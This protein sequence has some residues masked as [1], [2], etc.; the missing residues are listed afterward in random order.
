M[1]NDC[2]LGAAVPILNDLVAW[3]SSVVA[4]PGSRRAPRFRIGS[5]RAKLEGSRTTENC[6]SAARYHEYS[7]MS[8]AC[9]RRRGSTPYLVIR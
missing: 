3:S 6:E 8:S 1:T 4:S 5:A 2:N 7:P 9:S